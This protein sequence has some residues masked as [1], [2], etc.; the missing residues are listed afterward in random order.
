[1]KIRPTTRRQFL[2]GAGGFTLAL[3]FL[4]S[5]VDDKTAKAA[6]ATPKRRFVQ[7]CTNHGGIWGNNMYPD[8]ATLTDSMS[9][10]GRTVKRGALTPKSGALSPVLTA[11]AITPAL[12]AKMNVIRGC[13]VPWYIGHH[14]GGHMGN[15]ASNDGNGSEGK[16]WQGF[17]TPTIDQLMAWSPR[18][19]DDL[20]TIKQRAMVIESRPSFSFNYSNPSNATDPGP[21]QPVT[22]TYDAPALFKQIFVTSGTAAADPN[23]MMVPVVDRVNADY[24]RLRNASTRL[25]SNDRHRLDDHMQ[26]LSELQRRL[27][28]KTSCSP[29]IP[30][31]TTD[32]KKLVNSSSYAVDPTQH[33]KLLQAFNDVIVAAFLCDTSRIAVLHIAEDFSSFVGDWHEDVAHQ[34]N[35]PDGVKQQVIAAAHQ[36]VFE[37]VFVD[38]ATKLDVDD[39]TGKTYLD[40]S[41][42]VWTQE[43]GEY[44]HAGQGMPIITAGSAAGF[45]KTGNFVDYRNISS[46]FIYEAGE[47]GNK[48]NIY[49]GLLWQQWLG[50]AL[51]A[52]GLKPADYEK[53]GLGGYPGPMKYIEKNKEKLYPDAV[54]SAATEVLPFLKA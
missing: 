32:T 35:N 43:S 29:S 50:T 28:V 1:M 20:S 40:G 41:L 42:V 17:P 37:K 52:M 15:F 22:G 46:D 45:L 49:S 11:A 47:A 16:F 33:T 54:W 51:Q 53:N 24:Q 14:S 27:N 7:Y 30:A 25:S 5:L 12:A 39:G 9:Y 18:F 3:P 13:D 4:P 48:I 19:Y 34:A 36:L 31:V 10:A 26:R 6:A 23:A 2:R 21:V 38:L 8:A 44:T